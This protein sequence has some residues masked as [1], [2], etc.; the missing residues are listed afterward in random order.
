M[1]GEEF[2]KTITYLKVDFIEP[3]EKIQKMLQFTSL[4][5]D[6]RK[7]CKKMSKKILMHNDVFPQKDSL[8]QNYI[9]NHRE[10]FDEENVRFIATF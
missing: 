9:I 5:G 4:D 3:R 7:T 8:L 6:C 1:N 10:T 2:Q